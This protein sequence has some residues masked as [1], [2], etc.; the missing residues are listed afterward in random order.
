HTPSSFAD[1][2]RV[3]DAGAIAFI[4]LATDLG[5]NERADGAADDGG[6]HAIVAVSHPVTN[7]AADDS[8]KYCAHFLTIA[9]SGP[10]A[11]I[12]FPMT[13]G[14]ADVVGVILLAPAVCRCMGWR[15]RECLHDPSRGQ[16]CD[17]Q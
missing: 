8:A 10:H 15:S 6:N 9:A 2:E 13:A 1:L 12:A 11:V 7:D 3:S 14:I 4:H 17:Q 16:Q 5:T